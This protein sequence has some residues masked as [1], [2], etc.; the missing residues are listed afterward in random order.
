MEDAATPLKPFSM[1]MIA[2]VEK[3]QGRNDKLLA[4]IATE[5]SA[6]QAKRAQ[7]SHNGVSITKY[8]LPKKAGELLAE[9][10]YY[11][12]VDGSFFSTDDELLM[13]TLISRA[14][15]ETVVGKVLAQDEVFIEGRAKLEISGQAQL[16]YF[17]RP[18]GFARVLRAI[19][20]KRSKSNADMLAVL[21]NQGFSAIQCVCGELAL[22]LQK[23]D[24]SHRG[25]I[26][27]EFPL[28]MS[29]GVL[30][31][32]NKVT[33]HVPSF[34]GDKISSLLTTHWNAKDAFW[35]TE[36]LVD[37]LA[38]TP[39]VFNEVIEGIKKD[40]N[41]PR[42]DI[43]QEVLPHFT[44]DIYAIS[45]SREGE[46]DVDSRRN[47][48]A[49]RLNNA[50][51]M[52]KVLDRA[53]SNEPDAELVEAGGHQIWK[54]VHREDEEVLDLTADFGGDFGAPPAQSAN[55]PQPWLS[56]WAITVYD[57]YLMFAS[58]VEMIQDAIV[59]AENHEISPLLEESDY[60]RVTAAI[61]EHLGDGASSGWQVVRTKLAY[62]VQY[63]LFREGK[64]RQSQ[65][66]LASILDRLLQNEPEMRG[67]EQK[68]DG[69]KLPPFE[70]VA[71]FLQP[72]G[73]MFRT[74]EDG[75]QFG[76][77]MLSG[78]DQPKPAAPTDVSGQS[79]QGTARVSNSTVDN[80]R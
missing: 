65:S 67:K 59:Q 11:A 49:L 74:T 5:M 40:P 2:D 13:K 20:G 16:E 8:T 64:L 50:A 34:V 1:A 27:A 55:Q 30:D 61:Q 71:Q 80:K 35:R 22:G 47:L 21:E 23:L 32:P 70:E 18:L 38:G 39:G 44:N 17:V 36:G 53:M 60:Q 57:D 10:S 54:V 77:L 62:R 19:G 78:R 45:D 42:I 9:N 72:S 68:V 41:G 73:M 29:A 79:R 28:P 52:A 58:H 66:M 25:Y 24:I 63:E 69:S 37:E 76:S 3:H 75:W 56:N 15:G 7:L 46:A 51:A 31:F 43:A 33:H 48:I 26:L 4:T 14:Q 12:I 6:Q